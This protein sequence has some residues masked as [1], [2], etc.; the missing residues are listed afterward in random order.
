MRTK[1]VVG[2]PGSFLHDPHE[3]LVIPRAN[4]VVRVP[5]LPRSARRGQAF[6]EFVHAEIS[7]TQA[8]DQ[9]VAPQHWKSFV[10]VPKDHVNMRILSTSMFRMPV[11]S[12]LRPKNQHV[13]RFCLCDP[14]C[15]TSVHRHRNLT[16]PCGR[17]PMN[18]HRPDL[19]DRQRPMALELV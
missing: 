8:L 1:R 10:M 5:P 18:E 11:L 14:W 12:G 9:R 6:W 2:R 15:R 13:G 3:T 16:Y 4:R 19:L 7:R 17:S